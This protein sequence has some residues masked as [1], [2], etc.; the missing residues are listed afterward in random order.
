MINK[1]VVVH[2]WNVFLQG[3]PILGPILQEL[4]VTEHRKTHISLTKK[5]TPEQ[6]TNTQSV[7]MGVAGFSSRLGCGCFSVQRPRT[8]LDVVREFFSSWVWSSGVCVV[9]FQSPPIQFWCLKN[10]NRWIMHLRFLFA[11]TFFVI[12]LGKFEWWTNLTWI[13]WSSSGHWL[14]WQMCF[15]LSDWWNCEPILMSR[16]GKRGFSK[17]VVQSERTH[18]KMVQLNWT[19]PQSGVCFG[20]FLCVSRFAMVNSFRQ[21]EGLYHSRCCIH[22]Q[23][24]TKGFLLLCSCFFFPPRFLWEFCCFALKIN[25]GLL[26][27][28]VSGTCENWSVNCAS[29]SRMLWTRVFDE[30]IFSFLPMLV[31][32]WILSLCVSAGSL[33]SSWLCCVLWKFH[34]SQMS[35]FGSKSSHWSQSFVMSLKPISFQDAI[36]FWSRLHVQLGCLKS[37]EGKAPILENWG[38]RVLEGR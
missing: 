30:P 31:I 18:V 24:G 8:S 23:M 7:P 3:K 36:K 20:W 6:T 38:F 13:E 17:N 16:F 34:S 5:H 35:P 9:V 15:P 19:C 33:S 21:R 2:F 10:D 1:I 4:K 27:S 22:M 32:F 26:P 25:H 28:V 37:G 29:L 14:H 12:L 11:A